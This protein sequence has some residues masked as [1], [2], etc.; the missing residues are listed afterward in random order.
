MPASARGSISN[1]RSTEKD[2]EPDTD[3]RILEVMK[4]NYGPVGEVIT[5]RWKD[6]LFL[7]VAG[8]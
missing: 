5:L 1:V 7:P 6:G 3:L 8:P 4:S 2:E